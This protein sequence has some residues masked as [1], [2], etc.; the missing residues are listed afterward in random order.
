MI[1]SMEKEKHKNYKRYKQRKGIVFS[2]KLNLMSKFLC[3][4]PIL[5]NFIRYLD[6][7]FFDSKDRKGKF[8]T[9]LSSFKF[10]SKNF[11]PK[12]YYLSE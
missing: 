2:N 7:Y 4:E 6:A 1:V 10:P 3:F 8:S 9:E 11:V 12:E 5:K